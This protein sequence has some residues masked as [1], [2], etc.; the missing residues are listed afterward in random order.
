[1]VDAEGTG[2]NYQEGERQGNRISNFLDF[3]GDS[4]GSA[5]NRFYPWKL[6]LSGGELGWKGLSPAFRP[7]RIRGPATPDGIF[8]TRY[9]S[10][11]CAPSCAAARRRW[12]W[13][14]LP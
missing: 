5:A 4:C 9:C 11:R 2:D 6:M 8:C 13:R 7:W 12:T 3:I 14:S 10:S 1:M